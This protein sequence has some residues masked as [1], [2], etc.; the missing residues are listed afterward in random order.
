MARTAAS[1]GVSGPS[2]LAPRGNPEEVIQDGFVAF[3][4]GGSVSNELK[5]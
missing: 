4:A 5:H 1:S 3:K 2:W